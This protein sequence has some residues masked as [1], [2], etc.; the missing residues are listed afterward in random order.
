MPETIDLLIIMIMIILG[1]GKTIEKFA[2]AIA[3][4]M[5]NYDNTVSAERILELSISW[6]DNN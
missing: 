1:Y 6:G 5:Y 2:V 4:S 3:L